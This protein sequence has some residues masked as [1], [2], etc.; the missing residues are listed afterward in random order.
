MSRMTSPEKAKLHLN[1]LGAVICQEGAIL[2][3][4]DGNLFGPERINIM[5]KTIFS[6]EITEDVSQM[7]TSGH[8]LYETFKT[9]RIIPG[10]FNLWAPVKKNRLKLCSYI[11]DKVRV[12]VAGTITELTTH[13]TLF[14]LLL[15]V[16]RSQNDVDM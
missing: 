8:G 1:S 5:I 10:S 3:L 9:Q 14:A 7:H 4:Q 2:K 12:K 13:R 6:D 15:V 16:S 11:R